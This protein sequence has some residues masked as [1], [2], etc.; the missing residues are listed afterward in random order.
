[1]NTRLLFLS[2]LALAMFLSFGSKNPS[3]PPLGNT[4]APGESTCQNANCHGG[5]T[6]LA[7]LSIT[8]LP[9][10][11][12]ADSTYSLTVQGTN[13]NSLRGGFQL[14]VLDDANVKAGTL[15][16]ATGVNVATQSTTGRQYARH[17]A[18][19]TVTAQSVSW[20]FNWTAPS[21]AGEANFFYTML[22]A[23]GNGNDSGDNVKTGTLVRPV[24]LQTIVAPS[25]TTQP[26]SSLSLCQ[27]ETIT[28][29]VEATGDGPLTYTWQLD[30]QTISAPNSSTLTITNAAVNQ[31]GTYTCVVSNANTQN[32]A[33]SAGSEVTVQ[34]EVTPTVSI[35]TP[36]TTVLASE[37]VTFSSNINGGGTMPVYQWYVNGVAVTNAT[38]A[39][40][41]NS[42]W[43]D[44]DAVYCTM[45]S[46]A[47]CPSINTAISNVLTMQVASNSSDFAQMQT[48]VH[49]NPVKAGQDIL[50]AVKEDAVFR[51]FDAS[52]K[53]NIEGEITS[54]S[55]KLSVPSHWPNGTYFLQLTNSNG[56]FISTT[57]VVVR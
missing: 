25:I 36:N 41:T 35:A 1:M 39:T 56:I 38:S 54:V 37:S 50:I 51:L 12:K 52:G 17:S 53:F 34:P 47:A 44:N 13:N 10:T 48:K 11:L 19:K 40:W 3:N 30:G 4:G 7:D 20:T 42:T 28:L 57:Q 46:N 15:F 29:S 32:P 21:V 55:Q 23:N 14:T 26:V 6:Y 22:L 33:T 9:D 43:A 45:A 2:M 16:A 8:G 24:V 49:P 5:G 18:F 31:S 27:G